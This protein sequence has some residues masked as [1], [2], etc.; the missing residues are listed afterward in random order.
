MSESFQTPNIMLP[1]SMKPMP[2]N[3]FFSSMF[4]LRPR[5][6]RMRAARNAS[7]AMSAFPSGN[8]GVQFGGL[9]SATPPPLPENAR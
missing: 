3:I 5:A 2:P 1:L 6:S 9:I 8:I 7:K 4:F